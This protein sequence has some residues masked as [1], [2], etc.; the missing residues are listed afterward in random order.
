MSARGTKNVNQKNE[1]ADNMLLQMKFFLYKQMHASKA[2]MHPHACTYSQGRRMDEEGM[3]NLCGTNSPTRKKK[4]EGG[5]CRRR[6]K[7]K[8]PKSRI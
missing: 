5:R 1:N 6:G 2:A 4:K 7:K 3:C 8:K